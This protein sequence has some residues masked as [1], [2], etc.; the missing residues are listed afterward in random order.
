MPFESYVS[1]YGGGLL[2]AGEESVYGRTATR[3]PH[4]ERAMP[5]W[6]KA[7]SQATRTW[8]W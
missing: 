3:T 5:I 1:D 6:F 2:L 8:P 4:I 7:E